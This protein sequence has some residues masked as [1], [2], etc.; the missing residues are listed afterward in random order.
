MTRYLYGATGADTVT[1]PAGTIV[2]GRTGTAWTARIGGAQVT[3][4][5]TVDGAGTSTVTTDA[6]G[7]FAFY[8][9][10]GTT[11]SLWLDFGGGSG[12]WACQ[13]TDTTAVVTEVVGSQLAGSYLPRPVQDPAAGQVL[14]AAPD[15]ELVWS[16]APS[17]TGS[18]SLEA[19]PAV[20]FGAHR[21]GR[22]VA[23]EET[24]AAFRAMVAAGVDYLDMD[25][26]MLA[27]G[28]VVVH[29]DS[30]VDRITSST[31]SLSRMTATGYK[32]LR[33]KA[34]VLPGTTWP[35]LDLPTAAEVLS[36]FG[37]R[38]VMTI[39][40]KDTAA[41]PV[42]GQMIRDRG[43][44]GSVLLNTNTVSVVADIKAEGVL[45]HLWRDS[46]Q[47]SAADVVAVADAAPDVLEI[48]YAL[49]DAQI[50]EYRAAIP[51]ASRL[52]AHSTPMHGDRDRLISLGVTGIVGDD[53]IY[54][55]GLAPVTTSDPFIQQTFWHGAYTGTGGGS[56][57]DRGSF[58][59]PNAWGYADTASWRGLYQAW[60]S[61]IAAAAGTYT[62]SLD[63][64][65][66]AVTADTN[67]LAIYFGFS[68]DKP[69]TDGASD[70]GMNGWGILLRQRGDLDIYKYTDGVGTRVGDGAQPADF[71]IGTWSP[72]TIS[73]TPTTI[74]ANRP[75]NAEAST[76]V[77]DSNY[78]GG[79]MWLGASGAAG[80]FRNITIA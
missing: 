16:A 71:V 59:T 15:G 24:M 23:P 19:L 10:D 77:N 63:V 4:L 22:N 36:E 11:S 75:D 72:V 14:T 46:T 37:G 60:A 1:D 55:A 47:Y 12:R 25:A 28:T 26:R 5:Q 38:I 42:L 31:G 18:A 30:T 68:S 52:W 17:P 80:R 21:G 6:E 58:E 13:P 48:D 78:R 66:T 9:P 20:A 41:I 39:E 61:P 56:G 49:S 57:A 74:T 33:T 69:F 76:V 64:K 2:T 51:A 29:H 79:H 27:D 53:P 62:I 45:A 7:R 54:M 70:P 32:R 34:A 65:L 35:E 8:G 43:L 50:G 73:V 67:W 3:D 44:T 40:C